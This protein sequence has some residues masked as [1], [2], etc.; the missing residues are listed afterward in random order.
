MA[1]RKRHNSYCHP[2]KVWKEAWSFYFRPTN[3]LLIRHKFECKIQTKY[4]SHWKWYLTRKQLCIRHN[5]SLQ[6]QNLATLACNNH[7]HQ[8]KTKWINLRIETH[9][10]IILTVYV[11]IAGIL[12]I[13]SVRFSLANV[14]V[15][16]T[17]IGDDLNLIA[18]SQASLIEEVWNNL[19][20]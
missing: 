4:N 18:M 6:S 19:I 12:S 17:T 8:L 2:L 7:N 1:T 20:I 13:G 15:K 11:H 3:E 10:Q 5:S 14:R 16:A 9:V